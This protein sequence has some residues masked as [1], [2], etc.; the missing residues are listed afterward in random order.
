M[1]ENL[2]HAAVR[3]VVSKKPYANEH[4]FLYLGLCFVSGKLRRRMVFI[5]NGFD[6]IKVVGKR[7]RCYSWRSGCQMIN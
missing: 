4:C 5:H 7:F 1:F 3:T 6:A 2:C